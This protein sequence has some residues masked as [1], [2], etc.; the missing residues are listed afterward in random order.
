VKLRLPRLLPLVAL[1]ALA[2][3]M[4]CETAPATGSTLAEAR[5]AFV[6]AEADP[7]VAKFA[8]TE[9]ERARRLLGDAETASKDRQRV[10]ANAEHYAYLALQMTRIAEQRSRENLARMR[11]EAA[12]VERANLLRAAEEAREAAAAAAAPKEIAA[13][14]TAR[15][16][17][18]T[19][20]D[21][22]FDTDRIDLTPGAQR[23]VS[24]LAA[25]LAARPE[26]NVHIEGF[27]DD[28][29]HAGHN[30]E[31]SQTRADAIAMALIH[32]GIDPARIRATGFG[33]NFPIADN[34]DPR[35]RAKNRRVEIVVSNDAQFVPARFVSAR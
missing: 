21:V 27:T 9:L 6:A 25:W 5:A 19:I 8:G 18:L 4:A 13:R 22:L 11:V 24:E 26:R 23:T 10:T 3:L 33:E 14:K 35:K 31:L 32:A 15:G 16:L 12:E 2:T 20:N 28:V 7:Q 17:V 1:T 30:L 29:G 34:A